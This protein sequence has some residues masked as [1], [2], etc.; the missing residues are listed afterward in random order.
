[1]TLPPLV[2]PREPGAFWRLRALHMEED[3]PAVPITSEGLTIGRSVSNDVILISEEFPGVSATHA[4]LVYRAGVVTL[5]D[6]DSKNGTFVAGQAIERVVLEHGDVF[7][8]GRGGARFVVISPTRPDQTAHAWTISRFIL[9]KHGNI[10]KNLE[11]VLKNLDFPENLENQENV[12]K[13]NE[14]IG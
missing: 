13:H 11:K 14:K 8:L 3:L 2:D 6:L 10:L 7:E 4:R 1:M 9:K 12:L 5:E